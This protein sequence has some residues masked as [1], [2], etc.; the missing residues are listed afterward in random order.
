MGTLV[1]YYTWGRHPEEE[2]L[3]LELFAIKAKIIFPKCSSSSKTASKIF[4]NSWIAAGR[5]HE[6]YEGNEL[7]ELLEKQYVKRIPRR[8]AVSMVGLSLYRLSQT[9]EINRSDVKL[10]TL[11]KAAFIA[12]EDILSGK[13]PRL[14]GNSTKN[15][16]VA[17]DRKK[18]AQYYREYESVAH[19]L[20]AGMIPPNQ[21]TDTLPERLWQRMSYAEFFRRQ[22]LASQDLHEFGK[23]MHA[24]P[25]GMEHNLDLKLDAMPEK[26][27][28]Y[29]KEYKSPNLY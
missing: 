15:Y 24:P 11:N 29:L 21:E 19:Y 23:K 17:S 12:S 5:P 2:K 20:M 14:Q 3:I 16:N 13:F 6:E 4:R 1:A 10:A 9:A 28:D 25:R 22:F 8:I 7:E 18:L 26:I 27:M